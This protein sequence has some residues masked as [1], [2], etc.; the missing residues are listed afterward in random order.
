VIATTLNRGLARPLFRALDGSSGGGVQPLRYA[1]TANFTIR[2]DESRNRANY[3][4]YFTF[5]TGGGDLKSIVLAFDAAMSSTTLTNGLLLDT[6]NDLPITKVAV[7]C[8][9]ISH[10]V[11]FGGSRARILL[12]GE[13]DV[14]CDSIP[15]SAFNLSTIPINTQ[16]TIKLR[17]DLTSTSHQ[18]P[19]TA[20]DTRISTNDMVL[21]FDDAATVSDVDTFGPFTQSGGSR[22]ERINGYHP[23]IL[24]VHT[25]AIKAIIACGD[26]ITIGTGDSALNT[27]SG[28]GWFNRMINLYPS[29]KPAS[30]NLAVHGSQSDLGLSDSRLSAIY[31]YATDGVIAHGANDIGA[32]G[33]GTVSTL[34]SNQTTRIQQFRTAGIT[35]VLAMHL[36]PRTQ[37]TD[38]WSTEANQTPNTGWGV[39]GK[40]LEYSGLLSGLDVDVE[41]TMNSIRGTDVVKWLVNGTAQY[42]VVDEIHPSSVGHALMA[43]DAYDISG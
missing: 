12:S 42:A 30:C 36:T 39:G 16:I 29:P 10:P 26:S 35:N 40:S 14:H 23:R 15:A 20:F 25:T 8:N 1:T 43:Q 2:A 9:G 33:T 41:L 22:N 4:S 17:I 37:S 13:Y 31:V 21:F 34:I 11:T 7:E 24:G 28:A 27:I 5:F 18:V 6:P 3:V 32:S 38:D 19:Y